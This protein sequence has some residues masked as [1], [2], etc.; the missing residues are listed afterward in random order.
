M[1]VMIAQMIENTREASFM[2]NMVL[3]YI[4]VINEGF[5]FFV[6]GI[7]SQVHKKIVDII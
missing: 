7:V 3:F 1:M 2:S 5:V 6:D 4:G